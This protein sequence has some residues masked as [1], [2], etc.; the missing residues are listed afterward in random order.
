MRTPVPLVLVLNLSLLSATTIA[1]D[2]PDRLELL[3]PEVTLAGPDTTQHLIVLGVLGDRERRDLTA[4]ASFVST[5]PEVAQVD[6]QG[7]IRAVADGCAEIEVTVGSVTASTVVRVSR[8]SEPRRVSFRNEIEPV[9]TKLGC[10]QGGCHG[11]QHGKGGFKLSLLGFEAEP[12]F[13]AIVKSAEGR[14]VTPFAPDESLFLKKPT[15]TVAHGGGRRM[16]AGSAEYAL[17]RLWLEQG[18]LEPTENEPTV[19]ALQVLP[20]HRVLEVGEHQRLIVLATLSDG[21]VRDV[22]D[23]ARYDTLNEGTA[24]VSPTGVA[25]TVG[26]GETNIM[27]RYQGHAAMARLTVPYARGKPF[28]FPIH[29]IV[30]AKAEAKW[31]ELGL[32]PSDLCTDVEFLR[33]AM[34]DMLGTTPTLDEIDAFLTDSSPQKRALLIDR[35]LERPEYVDYWSLKWGDLLRINSDRLGAQGMLA[36]NLWL[37]ESF[38]ANQPVNQM[39]AEL[40]TAQ[41]SIYTNGPANYFRVA[42]NPED[43]AETTAQV[44]M[45]VRLQC[46]KCHHHPFEAY[47]QDDYYGLAAYFARV[48][49]KNS[50]EFGLFGREQVIYVTKAGEVRQPR[51]G[52]IMKPT[53]LNG[54]PADDDIDRRRA[55]AHW[56]TQP[57]N[58]WL[59]RNVV[60]RYWGYLMGKGLVNPIDDLRETNPPSNPELLNA[61]AD[62]FIKGGYDLKDLLRVIMT[63]RV[64]Q[65]SSQPTPDNRLDTAFFTHYT[66]KR[67]TAEQLL[68]AV[69]LATGTVEKFPLKPAGTRAIALP[70]TNY[71]SYFLDTF[72]RPGRVIACECERST[73]PNL[74]QALHMMNGELINRKVS[75]LDGRLARLLK[76]PK[77]TDDTLIQTLYRLSFNRPATDAEVTTAA[78]L[79]HEAPNRTLGAQDLFWGLLNSKEFLF[80]H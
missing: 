21:S 30:D 37:R 69:N 72:G 57:D 29:N 61:L 63:S 20:A 59:A 40:V 74:S 8:A 58:R 67:L 78:A 60:N 41:G 77:L 47:G 48:R 66:V 7:R 27:V 75:Q 56:L 44:F 39:V 55:L 70:D 50:D 68:D 49:T 14:R 22:T 36:F 52:Q 3:P 23:H 16:E 13:T 10:N 62:E 18:A 1:S 71:S 34:L 51:S 38:R 5:A 35:L 4:E 26:Q 17:I 28:D 76:D 2:V 45:G 53:P 80:N 79:I 24:R 65:L 73:D 11:S 54:S 33:R 9:L 32:A 43:L 6:A 64:Y 31:R 46:A 12:D 25:E 19:S 42:S 15:L